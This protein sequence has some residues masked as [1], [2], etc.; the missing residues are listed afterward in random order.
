MENDAQP[1]SNIGRSILWLVVLALVIVG[2]FAM[3]RQKE[4]RAI[5]LGAI[6]PITGSGADQ[7]EWIKR[8]FDLA[9]DEANKSSKNAIVVA[10]EDSNGDTTKALSA[11]KKLRAEFQIPVVLSWGSGVG[12]ALTS[13]V[14]QDKVI[15]MGV[16]TAANAYSTPDDFTFRNFPRAEQ[17]AAF[18]SDAVLRTLNN[19]EVAIL[20]INNDYGK[21]SADS[22][23][24]QFAKGGGR[25]TSEEVFAPND[26]DFRTQLTKLKALSPELIYLA[27]Y[28]KEGGLLLKQAKEL[29]LASRFIASVA[30]LGG[31]DF[32][33]L[34]GE[35]SEGL[36]VATSIPSFISSTE[37]N[38]RTFVKN[39]AQKFG[40]E[41]SAQ[42]IYTARAY[43]ALKVLAKALDTCDKDTEC[44]RQEL[45]TV[46]DYKG[47]SGTFSFDR[48]GDIS[49]EFN[50]Q[51]VRNGTFAAYHE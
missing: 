48:D 12:I 40:E 35:S 47:V 19:K 27:V 45:F 7:A 25:I 31:K 3:N 8:G 2:V 10:Y 18:L 42:H 36:I 9:L 15:Q 38:V 34:A 37:P 39:Y 43:D 11:Y 4:T 5:T 29:G 14:N 16:A 32:F 44:L 26:T 30:I 28:P 23:K 24:E 20:K 1:Q 13:L 51:I 49:A 6:L 46:K 17:E 22:F 33:N 21:S 50:L 41:P